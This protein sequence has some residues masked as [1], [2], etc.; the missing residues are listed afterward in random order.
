MSKISDLKY[1][2]NNQHG[3]KKRGSRQVTPI[4]SH[5][6]GIATRFAQGRRRNFYD[7]EPQRNFGNLC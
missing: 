2:E 7:P 1:D 6:Y 3:K 4:E 5:R